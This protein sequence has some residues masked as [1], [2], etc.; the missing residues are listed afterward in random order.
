MRWQWYYKRTQLN[1]DYN[2]KK[3]ENI[4]V[5]PVTGRGGP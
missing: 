2:A 5:V 3:K 1:N 4:E